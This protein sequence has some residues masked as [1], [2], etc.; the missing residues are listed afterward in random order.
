[1]APTTRQPF[2]LKVACVRGQYTY[3]AALKTLG[4][5]RALSSDSPM[6]GSFD[7]PTVEPSTGQFLTRYS[8]ELSAWTLTPSR[9]FFVA[10]NCSDQQNCGTSRSVHCD[11]A[12]ANSDEM[13][14]LSLAIFRCEGI[15]GD[16]LGFLRRER[17]C[18]ECEAKVARCRGFANR[19]YRKSLGS[20]MSR[21]RKLSNATPATTK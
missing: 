8:P 6:F 21:Y 2:T 14:E 4:A 16:V 15:Q 19:G 5:V 17:W 12:K 10:V 3:S 20:M 1:L 7:N 11:T 13:A 18:F 9:T